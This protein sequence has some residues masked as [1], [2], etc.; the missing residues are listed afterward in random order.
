M[1]PQLIYPPSDPSAQARLLEVLRL[2]RGGPEAVEQ[3]LCLCGECRLVCREEGPTLQKGTIEGTITATENRP[4]K[5][6]SATGFDTQNSA[7][8]PDGHRWLV[9]LLV[10]PCP[11][12]LSCIRYV[13]GIN[14]NPHPD[15]DELEY[16]TVILGGNLRCGI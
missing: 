12:C 3:R 16:L 6:I 13:F 4:D 11:H 15:N 7:A 8:S 14:R 2:A 1:Q 9:R 5:G 10:M